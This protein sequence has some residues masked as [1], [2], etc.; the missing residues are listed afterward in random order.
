MIY[1]LKPG[2]TIEVCWQSKVKS[3]YENLGYQ[4]THKDEKFLVPVE[5]LIPSSDKPVKLICDNC[6]RE[7]TGPYNRHYERYKNGQEDRCKHC[8][9]LEYYTEKKKET[10]H[11][12]FQQ[13]KKLCLEHGY[14]LLTD[15]SEYKSSK[16]FIQ[17]ICPVHGKQTMLLYN[18]LKGH[19]CIECSYEYRAD[20]CRYTP[21]Q[22]E[23]MIN[24]INGNKLLN[25]E[26]YIGTKVHN[27]KILCGTCGTHVYI[28]SLDDYKNNHVH[29]CRS[30]SSVESIGEMAVAEHL[31]S[32]DVSYIREKKFPECKDKR[33]LPFDFYLPYYNAIIEFDGQGHYRPLWGEAAYQS[34]IQHDKIKNKFCQDNNIPLLRIPYWEGKQI[35]QNV[36]SFLSEITITHR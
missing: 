17:F 6:G 4:F 23:A 3:Y 11:N 8:A 7:Y 20:K 9:H 34:T 24:S 15:E 1:I 29:R 32:I 12:V 28:T 19:K 18:F 10:A 16:M 30:C 2:Q 13:V 14:E 26:E 33:E 25:K 5:H 21:D 35:P 36:N 27:L 22:V 31:N